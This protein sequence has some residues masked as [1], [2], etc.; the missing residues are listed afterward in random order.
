MKAT[1]IIPGD[2]SVGIPDGEMTVDLHGY[3]F[4]DAA[5]REGFRK[6]LTAFAS[7][8]MG[9]CGKPYVVFND[10][11]MDCGRLALPG[12][13]FSLKCPNPQCISNIPDN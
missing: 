9:N 13:E 2:R 6:G 3:E 1:V 7:E 11:C 10:E 8:Y 4:D 5:E 12:M